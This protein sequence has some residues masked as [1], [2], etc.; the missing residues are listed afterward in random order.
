[1]SQS[2]ELNLYKLFRK[3]KQHFK[4][5]HTILH[6]LKHTNYNSFWNLFNQHTITNPSASWIHAQHFISMCTWPPKWF[7]SIN[8]IFLWII[9][10]IDCSVANQFLAN[11]ITQNAHNPNCSFRVHKCRC[12][13]K[14]ALYWCSQLFDTHNCFY[15]CKFCLLHKHKSIDICKKK[16]P[17]VAITVSQLTQ[18]LLYLKIDSKNS[19][20][21]LKHV[22]SFSVNC[23]NYQPSREMCKFCESEAFSSIKFYYISQCPF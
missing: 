20:S 2:D 12:L 15:L 13:W 10:T 6:A 3:F 11:L 23:R 9:K 17:N 4:H 14:I 8:F 22:N 19:F 16:T 21:K 18:Y 7:A 1:M 5:T